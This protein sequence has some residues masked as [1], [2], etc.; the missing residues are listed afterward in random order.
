MDPEIRIV[1][2]AEALGLW[3]R[4]VELSGGGG[5]RCRSVIFAGFAT[6]TRPRGRR[7]LGRASGR[8]APLDQIEWVLEQYRTRYWDFTA[9]HFHEHLV[10]DHG[11]RLGYTW[12]KIR[13]PVL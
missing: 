11:F 2:I 10:R 1:R 13:L 8:R 4:R 9:K 3:Q 5:G 12:T 6:A 7:A